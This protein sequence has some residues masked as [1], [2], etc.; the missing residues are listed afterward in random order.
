M[1]WQQDNQVPVPPLP[2]I[3]RVGLIFLWSGGDSFWELIHLN[4]G[5]CLQCWWRVCIQYCGLPEGRAASFPARPCPEM[6]GVEWSCW[7]SR[8]PGPETVDLSVAP[9][10]IAAALELIS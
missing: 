8:T 6:C 7:S 3:R 10:V 9:R 4:D 1:A 5:L 2:P